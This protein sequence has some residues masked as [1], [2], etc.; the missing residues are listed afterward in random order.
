MGKIN[1]IK[2]FKKNSFQ[3]LALPKDRQS[4]CEVQKKCHQIFSFFFYSI[5][6]IQIFQKCKIFQ[7]IPIGSGYNSRHKYAFSTACTEVLF[8]CGPPKDEKKVNDCFTHFQLDFFEKNFCVKSLHNLSLI[9][10]KNLKIL[11][12]FLFCLYYKRS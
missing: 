10:K 6:I 11:K 12:I 4:F 2:I 7:K 8:P 1:N 9:K 3:C 5:W